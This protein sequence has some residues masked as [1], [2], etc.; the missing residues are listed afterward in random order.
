MIVE[1]NTDLREYI[2]ENLEDDYQTIEAC[3]GEEGFNKG[4]EFIPD[5]I[6]SDVMMPKIDG[7]KFCNMIKS[8]ERTSHIPV[9]LLTAKASGDTKM[10]G[11]ETGADDYI[12][13][14]FNAKEL[15]VR[16]RNLINQRRS[17]RERFKKEITL[18]PKE[19][20]ITSAD[21]KFLQKIIDYIET[22]ISDTKLS[23]ESMGKDIGLSRVQLYR[24]LHA[25][26]DQSVSEFIRTYR[27]KR[28]AQLLEQKKGNIS[29]IAY[30]VGFNEPSYFTKCFKNQFG[31]SPSEFNSQNKKS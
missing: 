23:V 12:T 24:K 31:K 13:K 18:E 3:N 28:A 5:L 27:L 10:K 17:L 1:D 19:I 11:L 15:L 9:I 30:E 26:T 7:I 29:E 6:I 21:E 25:L 16:V 22:N 14:P 20:A 8:D 2:R 4:I